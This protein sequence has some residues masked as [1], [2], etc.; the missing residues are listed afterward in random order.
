MIGLRD[1]LLFRCRFLFCVLLM[2]PQ[3]GHDLAAQCAALHFCFAV[4]EFLRTGEIPVSVQLLHSLLLRVAEIRRAVSTIGPVIAQ[5]CPDIRSA[6]I[7]RHLI[8]PYAFID[9]SPI[10]CARLGAALLRCIVG[11][12]RAADLHIDRYARP[13]RSGQKFPQI[14]RAALRV[15]I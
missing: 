3:E 8:A 14:R 2:L 10:L 1:A 5:S 11:E 12:L 15:L 7:P 4:G 13:V 9:K 6:V